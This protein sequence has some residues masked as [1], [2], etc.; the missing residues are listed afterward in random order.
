MNTEIRTFNFNDMSVRTLTD[1]HGE[2]WFVAKD[3]C[4]I[5]EISNNR[6]AISQ[7]D[8]DEKNTVVISD[9]IAGNPNKPLETTTH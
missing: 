2:P 6:D 3:V 1:E 8:S 5:L 4:D 7:L 9:G